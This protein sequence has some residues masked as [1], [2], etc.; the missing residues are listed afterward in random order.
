[1]SPLFAFNQVEEALNVQLDGHYDA[2][3]QLWVGGMISVSNV[4]P[5]IGGGETFIGR[6]T[7]AINGRIVQ[8]CIKD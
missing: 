5:E 1:M 7:V 3:Q 8:D 4:E 2:L 6:T